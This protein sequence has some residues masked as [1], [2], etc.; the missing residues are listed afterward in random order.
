[1][2]YLNFLMISFISNNFEYIVNMNKR[3][4]NFESLHLNEAEQSQ[5]ENMKKLFHTKMIIYERFLFPYYFL[6]FI[7]KYNQLALKKNIDNEK[8]EFDNF[9]VY[10]IR[11][12]TKLFDLQK[13]FGNNEATRLDP[14]LISVLLHEAQDIYNYSLTLFGD[15]KMSFDFTSNVYT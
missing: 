13:T 5:A 4:L 1:M 15:N 8:I 6:N 9:L 3:K 10:D 2:N 12:K 14:N 7:G 11:T